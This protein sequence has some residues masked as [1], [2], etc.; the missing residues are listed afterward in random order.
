VSGHGWIGVDLDGTLAHYDGWRDGSIGKPIQVMVERVRGWLAQGKDVRIFTARVGPQHSVERPHT[1]PPCAPCEDQ[2]HQVAFIEDWCREQFGR[3]LP[4]TA[5]KDLGMIE[6]WDDRAVQV[7]PNTGIPVT[8]IVEPTE[9]RYGDDRTIHRSG[10]VDVEIG[11]D[12][13]VCAVWFRCRLLCFTEARV[14]QVRQDEMNRAYAGEV[15]DDI[16]LLKAVV[17]EGEPS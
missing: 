11:P 4:I 9:V 8:D 5:T 1:D 13:K 14:E 2:A 15:N 17:F 16:P 6:L 3:A 7:V 12:G 10:T